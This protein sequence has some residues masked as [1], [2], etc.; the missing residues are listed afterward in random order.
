MA[1]GTTL[2]GD[3]V[4]FND[5]GIIL[6]TPESKYTDR[7]PWLKFSQGGLTQLYTNTQNT[8]VRP[9]VAP[10]ILPP[11]TAAEQPPKPAVKINEVS[12]L[13]PPAPAPIFGAL[14]SSPVVLF[15]LLLVY[16]ANLYAGYVVARYRSKSVGVVMGVSAVVPIAGPAIFLS[17][18]PAPAAAESTESAEAADA[19]QPA[20]VE[21]EPHRF[22]VPGMSPQGDIHIVEASWQPVGSEKPHAE[23]QIFQR[24]QFMFNRRFFETRFPGFFGSIRG[25]DDRHKELVVKATQGE[26]I[27]ERITRI[28]ANDAHF[29]L[30]KAGV[31]QEVI[32]PF[33][34]MHEVRVNPKGA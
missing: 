12:R 18:T 17:M 4:S 7:L 31:H 8:K 5:S 3:I 13:D 19:A 6:R 34:D 32:V 25:D 26:F 1:D 10:F 27:V 2:T 30:V 22:T 28:G 24:G 20:P 15:A 29:E 21:Q 14:V 33:A 16:A 23:S 9:F 11:A